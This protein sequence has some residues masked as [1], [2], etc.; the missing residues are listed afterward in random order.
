MT[1]ILLEPLI[2]RKY[3]QNIQNT[4]TSILVILDVSGVFWS[5]YM[6]SGIL[7]IIWVSEVFIDNFFLGFGVIL[8]SGVFWSSN[9]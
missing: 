7:V 3:P 9:F 5:S 8:V 4:Q 2:C 1:E 6:F